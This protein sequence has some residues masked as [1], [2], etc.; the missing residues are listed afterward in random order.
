MKTDLRVLLIIKAEIIY[1]HFLKGIRGD[2][3]KDGMFFRILFQLL[4]IYYIGGHFSLPPNSLGKTGGGVSTEIYFIGFGKFVV[5]D[6]SCQ[7]YGIVYYILYIQKKLY[8]ICIFYFSF[9][10][11]INNFIQRFHS[12]MQYGSFSQFYLLNDPQ[13]YYNK[14]R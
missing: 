9:E 10:E 5:V 14:W 6:I 3:G 11:K 1:W 2:Q 12:K 4:S 7:S 8:F 13:S